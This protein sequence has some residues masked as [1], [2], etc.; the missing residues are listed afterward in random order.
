MKT[1]PPT[2]E[3]IAK[4]IEAEVQNNIPL[5]K[6]VLHHNLYKFNKLILKAEE[7]KGKVPLAPFHLEMCQF[8]EKYKNK[9]KLMLLPRG[10]LKSTLIT[11]GYSL[12]QLLAN[13]SIRILIGN[14]TYNLARSFLTDI[15]RQLKFNENIHLI[16]GDLSKDP[17]KWSENEIMLGG[18]KTMHGKKEPN[19]TAMGVESNLTSQHYDLIILDD[20][21]NDKYV[22]TQEQIDKTINF[23]KESLNLLEP[24]GQAIILGTRW[25]DDDL[26][27]WIMDK[28][29]HVLSDFDV[30]VKRAYEGNL[31]GEYTLLYPEKFS[32]EH[33]RRLYQQQGPYFFSSQYLNDPIPQEDADFKREWFQ[34]FEYND[35]KAKPLNR[36]TMIDPAL[37]Q[38]K[39]SDFT[40]IVTVALDDQNNIYILDVRRIQAKPQGVIEEIFKV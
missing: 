26:Y 9:K 2:K 25:R 27:G 20:L 34:Y 40:A 1:P 13:P 6:E 24:N 3:E 12:Q 21:V 16:W 8:V 28:D 4:T 38:E 36:F 5:A 7:G 30:M 32:A 19:V 31:D 33:L 23:Y 17:E 18:I 37:S 35:L 14:A 10:H 22:N 39:S 29:N 15:K 11:V